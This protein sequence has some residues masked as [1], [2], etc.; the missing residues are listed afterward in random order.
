VLAGLC[1]GSTGVAATVIRSAGDFAG[2]F[3]EGPALGLGNEEGG[4]ETAQHE[5]GKNLHDV[6]DPGRGTFAC[7]IRLCASSAER[8]EYDL[9]NDGTDFARGGGDAMGG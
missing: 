7:G 8:S 6:V 1:G 5:E 2:E 4:E 9:G 3:L